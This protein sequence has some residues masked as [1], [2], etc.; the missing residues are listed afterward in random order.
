MKI[1]KIRMNKRGVSEM[2]S[3]VILIAISIGIS[4]GV[5]IWLKDFANVN[6][7]IDCKDGTS[8]RIDDVT[9]TSDTMTIK[10]KNNGNFNINGFIILASDDVNRIPTRK[11]SAIYQE[12]AVPALPGYYDFKNKLKPGEEETIQFLKGGFVEIIQIQ[13]YVRDDKGKITVCEKALIKQDVSG[14]GIL[15]IN[16]LSF[17]GIIS[18]WAFNDD[19]AYGVD[20]SNYISNNDGTLQGG[21]TYTDDPVR[22]KVLSLD[23]VNDYVDVTVAQDKNTTVFWYKNSTASAWTH[24]GFNTTDYFINGIKITGTPNEYPIYINGNTVYIG[25]KDASTFFN[26]SIDDVMIFDRALSLGDIQSLYQNPYEIPEG[27]SGPGCP[28]TVCDTG[29]DFITCPADCDIETTPGLVSWWKFDDNADDS[30][31][32]NDGVVNEAT[33]T[34]GKSENALQFD[35][36]DDYVSVADDSNLNIN[37]NI[38]LSVWINIKGDG[39]NNGPI[40]IKQNSDSPSACCDAFIYALTYEVSSKKMLFGLNTASASWADIVKS[41]TLIN[42][43]QWYYVA[44]TYDGTTAKIYIDGNLDNSTSKTGDIDSATGGSLFIGKDTGNPAAHEFFN[45]TIDNVM[46]LN[47]ALDETTIYNIYCATGGSC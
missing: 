39:T 13:P 2:I 16:P 22:G 28:N 38:T 6:P 14:C 30:K 1:R 20:D 46:I 19:P 45:G 44:G 3:Y 15:P 7:R 9:C 4:I 17:D 27:P 32:G 24:M 33:W 34:T 21:A 23:G 8:L 47:Q 36:V 40:V 41:N 18:W 11:L 5:F 12:G 35:G 42:F 10:V 29:E 37:K 25:K 26:G 31:D 43:N